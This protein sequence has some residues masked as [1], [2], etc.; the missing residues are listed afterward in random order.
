[1]LSGTCAR[2]DADVEGG[3]GS[4]GPVLGG[5]V[6]AAGCPLPRASVRRGRGLPSTG[7]S[8]FLGAPASSAKA[9]LHTGHGCI[10]EAV[11][12]SGDVFEEERDAAWQRGV[13]EKV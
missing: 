1:M 4:R 12:V 13:V 11:N 3:S 5:D 6:C 8:W 2:S 9:P 7:H 10:G